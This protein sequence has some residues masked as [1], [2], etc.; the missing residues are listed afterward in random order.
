MKK[1][2]SS[3][4]I[5]KT[6]LASEELNRHIFE[7]TSSGIVLVNLEGL[8]VIANAEAKRLLGLSSDEPQRNY[9]GLYE[10]QTF[11]E[12]GTPCPPEDYPVMRCLKTG[13]PQSPVTI[14]VRHPDGEIR[15]AIYSA[16]PF[17]DPRGGQ[18]IGALVTFMDV[19]ERKKIEERNRLLYDRNLVGFFRSTL[20]GRFLE[21][22]DG[23]ARLF[24]FETREELLSHRS[25]E[26]YIQSGDRSEYL[27]RLKRERAINNIEFALKRRDG[28][29]LWIVE[30]VTYLPGAG[31]S[32]E[33]VIEGAMIDLTARKMAETAL[34]EAEN[35]FRNLVE[36]SLVGVYILQDNHFVYVNPRFTEIMGYTFDEIRKRPA[37]DYIF[38][39]DRPLVAENIRRRIS[40]EIPSLHYTTRAIHKNGSIVQLEVFGA[41]TMLDDRPAVIGTL[42]DITERKRSEEAL[43]ESYQ[44]TQQVISNA[45]EGIVVYD[46]NFRYV[47][48]NPYMEKLT[49]LPASEVLGKTPM[50]L[51]PEMNAQGLMQILEDVRRGSRNEAVDFQYEIP[52]TQ[53]RGWVTGTYHP[54]YNAAG[55]VVGVIG[56][57]NDISARKAIENQLAEEKERLLVTLRSIGDGVITTDVDGRIVLINKVAEYLTG[58]NQEE[59]KGGFLEKVF[60]ISDYD[61]RPALNPVS[62][63]LKNRHVFI[64][65]EQTSL[66][67]KDGTQ[68]IISNSAAPIHDKES[69]L[70]GVVLV[71]RDVTE[72]QKMEEELQKSRK[73]ESLGILAG[74]IAHDFNN[75]LTSILGNISLARLELSRTRTEK[76]NDIL[77]N[78]EKAS[79]M[80]RD[81]TKQLLTF[82][83]GG[84]PIKT[85]ALIRD[86]LQDSANFALA[87]SNVK[88][89]FRIAGDLANA[90]IDRSQISQVIHNLVLNA[91]QAMPQGGI[92]DISA[93]NLTLEKDSVSDGFRI[94]A[95][96][97]IKI[98]I[99]D[100]GAGIPEANLGKIFDPYFTTKV[101]GS[102]LG[103]A[104]SY[105]IVK[106]HGGYIRVK[107]Q[108]GAGTTFEILLPSSDKAILRPE[109]APVQEIAGKGTVLIMDDE[110]TIR[111]ILSR[112]LTKLGLETVEAQDGQEAI[113]LYRVA[114]ESGRPF[115]AIIMDLTIPGGMGGKETIT[116]LKTIDPNVRAIVSSG[117]SNDPI[118]SD[119]ESYGF[120][121]ILSKP[122]RLED[123]ASVMASILRSD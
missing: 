30:N 19:T 34:Q 47:V 69:R 118:M 87:G 84:A 8:I 70:I 63:V 112:M 89:T 1:K 114:F 45:G 91:M 97:F 15:W 23:L 40:G 93:E 64:L 55:E 38:A 59:A 109:K 115:R 12:D 21:C 35:K 81:L 88:C 110:D 94:H 20:D 106:N 61:G 42:I 103:L 111:H 74:G 99:T 49:G 62:Q 39:P 26:F 50:E 46:Y 82:S 41:A 95:G 22:N 53:R 37:V 90:E 6:L 10:D 98:S 11:W 44:F 56:V 101:K 117:Y 25:T 36:Q 3:A 31:P 105:S 86:L 116:R 71:F 66:L 102:G 54:N 27:E 52:S 79:F 51:F 107:S 43:R 2:K 119:Y 24:G 100:H 48:W 77:T 58:W 13:R 120:S 83:K 123:L 104:T 76:L 7:N 9:V 60:Q 96:D 121:N 57:I 29:T 17:N 65:Q 67:S 72:K 75:I 32:G 28:K 4:H 113:D 122:Y 68:R 33:D 78:A 14:G 16:T 5:S 18:I 80:A 85:T 73:I 92:I 108:V